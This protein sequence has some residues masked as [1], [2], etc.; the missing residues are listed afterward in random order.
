MPRESGN[1]MRIL[2]CLLALL[3]CFAPA[4]A[5]EGPGL[6]VLDT[7]GSA[8]LADENG[9]VLIWPGEYA[10]ITALGG[11][12]YAAR[13]LS[14]GGLGLIRPD[15]TVV[16]EFGYA[17]FEYDEGRIIYTRDGKCGVMDES[18]ETLV[19]PVYT[20]LVPA[21]EEGWLA[22]RT[23]PL[24]DTPDSLWH[25]GPGGGERVTGIKLSYGPLAF[26]EN[27]SEAADTAGRW[28]YLNGAG[29]W[30]IAPRFAWCGP[31]SGGL[32]C[33][34]TADGAGLID[35]TGEWVAEPVYSRVERDPS[36]SLPFLAFGD[37]EVCL[38]SP[39]DGALAAR[40]A[41]A[42]VGAGYAGELIRVSAGGR[43]RLVN[44]E[45]ET[46]FEAEEG[47]TGL[48]A[49]G[50]CV[51]QRRTVTEE[52]PFSFIGVDGAA[53]GDWQEL[54]FAGLYGDRAYFIFSEYETVKSEYGGFVFY[55]EALGTRR[56][57]L[58]NDEGDPVAGGFISLRHAGNDL[59]AAETESWIGLIQPDGTVIIRLEKEE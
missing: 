43:L 39:E 22:L 21:G 37:D 44:G 12:L 54:S 49:L 5:E 27:L 33:A 25:I 50:G 9:T 17:S 31:F 28:G 56:Y 6:C 42:G 57:G 30:A 10:E 52:R 45:G 23:D 55:D 38:L 13:P 41:S 3:A 14:G 51:L 48:S 11:G 24:D 47:V 46:V 2:I 59:L 1:D 19:E 35:R 8:V 29:E 15:G 26:S 58:L 18:G 7:N 53:H 36:G 20:R 40:F 16:T 4:A 34:A 32:A